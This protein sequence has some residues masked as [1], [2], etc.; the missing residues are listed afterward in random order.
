MEGHDFKIYG[1]FNMQ[2]VADLTEFKTKLEE[3]EQV[4]TFPK[5]LIAGDK[6]KWYV[7][8]D[9]VYVLQASN[10]D[11]VLGASYL[12]IE[13]INKLFPAD[14]KNKFSFAEYRL[15]METAN[16]LKIIKNDKTAF[17]NFF[18]KAKEIF[19]RPQNEQKY[20]QILK[21]IDEADAIN[22]NYQKNYQNEDLEISKIF[23]DK[24]FN[25][26]HIDVSSVKRKDGTSAIVSTLFNDAVT[27]AAIMGKTQELK[28]VPTIERKYLK[29]YQSPISDALIYANGRNYDSD[30]RRASIKAKNGVNVKMLSEN[31][32]YLNG[33]TQK[34]WLYCLIQLAEILPHAGQK[35][36][37][38]TDELEHYRTIEITLKDYMQLTGLKDVKNAREHLKEA[39]LLLGG[40]ITCIDENEVK[41]TKKGK[42]TIKEKAVVRIAIIDKI[43]LGNG[44][45]TV[46]FSKSYIDYLRKKYL[47][48]FKADIFKINTQYNQ[49]SLQLIYRMVV[50]YNENVET[51]SNQEIIGVKTLID[52]L[53][54]LITFE[55][56]KGL[57]RNYKHHIIEKFEKDMNELVRT[58]LLQSWEYHKRAKDGGGVVPAE[59]L[60]GI[61]YNDWE[62][63]VIHF[64]LSE[65]YPD[66]TQRLENKAARIEKATK[67]RRRKKAKDETDG[68]QTG[69][70]GSGQ[71]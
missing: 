66:Q 24:L 5:T 1:M 11:D 16:V 3:D 59:E 54:N 23:T 40:E 69:N 20:D 46:S 27:P 21:I 10:L 28:G 12:T 41:T 50:H 71:G 42:K 26:E 25:G 67:R 30:S 22:A 7:S 6:D 61:K 35:A 52:A 31:L 33:N 58:G 19:E 63:L 15:K 37:L 48:D 44:R 32:Q 47:K 60:D 39:F 65:D 64:K 8:F 57:N 17:N 29:A 49:N 36:T 34:V 2:A 45:M 53:P 38:T 68:E 43:S 55:K 51:K 13:E 4:K 56:V 9:N 14:D 18:E 62:Q 70:D